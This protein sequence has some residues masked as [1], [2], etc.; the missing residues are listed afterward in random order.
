MALTDAKAK[1]ATVPEGMKQ[2]KLADGGG[3]YLLVK[4]SGKYWRMKYRFNGKEGS[5]LAIGVYPA[6]SLKQARGA[7]KELLR[8]NIDP[9]QAK[10]ADKRKPT[11]E[12]QVVKFEGVAK[13]WYEKK[14]PEWAES[15]AKH[16]KSRLDN[17]IL[18]RIGSLP[19][20]DIEP[21]EILGIA[22]G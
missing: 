2:T 5:P 13:E 11:E 12:A 18:P 22:R 15:T 21:F 17:Y 20:K 1:T 9:N 7:S 19:V 6:V 3:L 8:K 10:K 14:L 16:N 4:P